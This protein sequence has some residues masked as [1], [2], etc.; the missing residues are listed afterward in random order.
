M[1]ASANEIADAI[2]Q[3]AEAPTA[4]RLRRMANAYARLEYTVKLA[5]DALAA[6]QCAEE[7]PKDGRFLNVARERLEMILISFNSGFPG[8]LIG[9]PMQSDLGKKLQKE[10]A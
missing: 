10:A 4:H 7:N 9:P 8:G 5:D 6:L 3:V 1:I 2:R